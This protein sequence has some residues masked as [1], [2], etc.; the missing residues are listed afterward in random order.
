MTIVRP[1][2]TYETVIP[3]PIGGWK[4]YTVVDRMKKGRK[5]IVHGDG[6][7]LWT[8]THAADFARGFI[9]LLGNMKAVGQAFQITSDETLTWNEIYGAV[10]E[11]AGVEARPVHIAS[12][13][14]CAV[15]P[16]LTGTLLGDK[17]HSV[18]FD[19]SKIKKFV[20]DFAA[21]IH[22]REGIA[23]TLKWFE[24]DPS[25]MVV[26]DATN[27]MMDRIIDFYEAKGK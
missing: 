5:I 15:E 18:I 6:T 20:P 14:I 17:A 13:F 9:G 24:A 19:N 26:H 16:S 4:E 2:L 8:I 12:D 27:R 25:R 10:A 22:F 23:R 21:A 3:V 11:A 1:S 7:S